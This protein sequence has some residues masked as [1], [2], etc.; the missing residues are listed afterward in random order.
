MWQWVMGGTVTWKNILYWDDWDDLTP[1][2]L[3]TILLGWMYIKFCL[4]IFV[5]CLQV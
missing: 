5:A 2:K 1:G 3:G 4:Q